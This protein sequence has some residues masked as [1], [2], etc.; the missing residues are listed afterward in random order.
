MNFT[1]KDNCFDRLFMATAA[2]SGFLS[3][4]GSVRARRY[5]GEADNQ[6]CEWNE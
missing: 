1:K 6:L 4:M 5:L 2:Y 3:G